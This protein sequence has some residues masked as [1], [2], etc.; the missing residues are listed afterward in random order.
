[1][2]AV[3][4]ALRADLETNV[5]QFKKDMN[6]GGNVVDKTT[7]RMKASGDA[8]A[9][10]GKQWND[11]GKYVKFSVGTV[12]A[13]ALADF[14]K[15][16]IA[17]AVEGEKT[18][19]RL[20]NT[21]T[22]MGASVNEWATQTAKDLG[23]VDGE[24]KA[25]VLQFGQLAQKLVPTQ[26]AA[27][28]MSEALTKLSIDLAE[29]KGVNADEA[30]DKLQAALTGSTKGLREFG[31]F[32]DEN[33]V[34][35]KAV[36]MGLAKTT[37]EVSAQDRALATYNLILEKTTAIQ[38]TAAKQLD[39]NE[40]RLRAFSAQ[41]D[42]LAGTLGQILLPPLMAVIQGLSLYANGV[43]TI[44]GDTKD[45]E[46]GVLVLSLRWAQMTGGDIKPIVEKFRALNEATNEADRDAKT[47]GGILE[48]EFTGLA[49]T[50][51]EVAQRSRDVQQQLTGFQR[52]VRDFGVND[53][54]TVTQMLAQFSDGYVTLTASIQDTIGKLKAK[55]DATDD[56]K[57]AIK[58]LEEYLTRLDQKYLAA[59]DAAEKL[60]NATLSAAKAQDLVDVNGLNQQTQALAQAS[61]RMGVLSGNQQHALDIERQLQS[62]RL[63]ASAQLAELERQRAQ[64]ELD[65]D[66]LQLSRLASLQ[67]AAQAYYDLLGQTSAQQI[68]AQEMVQ[69]MV[70]DWRQTT[71]R[72]IG[73][74]FK[75]W[76]DSTDSESEQIAANFIRAISDSVLD[77]KA[78]DLA[79]A[80][81]DWLGIGGSKQTVSVIQA[82]SL[83]VATMQIPG[84]GGGAP[85]A[86]ANPLGQAW[87]W[88]SGATAGA[89]NWLQGVFSSFGGFFGEGGS[90]A[91]HQWGIA[92]E[93]GMEIVS[94]G[95]HG[96]NIAP[97]SDIMGGGDMTQNFYITT[98]NPDGFRQ[99]R[100]QIAQAA[101]RELG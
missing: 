16:S 20:D 9:K 95:A 91:P 3:V 27:A 87:D 72:T 36:A 42:S 35:Q 86:G 62:E 78:D 76:R 89:G 15:S 14:V 45:F 2:P 47:N 44:L 8:A 60:T 88:I 85:A 58:V 69:Q 55:S 38:G 28:D 30:A 61:G 93:S 71:G 53:L 49:L 7:K 32:I 37:K 64:A 13:L 43:K 90:L 82:G 34:K 100:R 1:M 74:F 80:L 98:P 79:N 41:I 77:R 50:A 83:Q 26:G 96:A 75:A 52:Q 57:A 17:A 70:D 56:E 22:G 25:T 21:F 66:D 18:G 68:M 54:P 19:R 99:S 40:S 46:K 23:R 97:L 4:G 29:F 81:F 51:D 10:A 84:Q 67:T 92:G 39:T 24:V 101:R 65:N 94:G 6:E 31:I 59:S 12:G 63:R 5:A 33:E 48:D 11:F 73:D